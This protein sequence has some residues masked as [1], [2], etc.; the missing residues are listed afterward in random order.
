M[1]GAAATAAAAAATAAL[2]GEPFIGDVFFERASFVLVT[3]VGVTDVTVLVWTG[4]ADVEL[5]F[6]VFELA[7][8]AVVAFLLVFAAAAAAFSSAARLRSCSSFNFA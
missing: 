7:A 8:A 2:F 6:F 5:D 4:A 3:G 1:I